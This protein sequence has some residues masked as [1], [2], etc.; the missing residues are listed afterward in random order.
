MRLATA[1]DRAGR[2]GDARTTY[3]RVLDEF[4]ASPYLGSAERELEA[5]SNDG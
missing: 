2:T 4:P 3:Q 1:Y 5:L